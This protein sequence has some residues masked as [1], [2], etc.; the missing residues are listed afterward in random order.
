MRRAAR[1]A[2][3]E[4]RL[5]WPRFRRWCHITLSLFSDPESAW[6]LHNDDGDPVCLSCSCGR[7]FWERS[8]E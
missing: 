2:S 6:D 5:I 8:S 7:I 1:R 3:L 4:I